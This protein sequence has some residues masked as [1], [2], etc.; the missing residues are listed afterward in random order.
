VNKQLVAVRFEGD[1]VPAVGTE[2]LQGEQ[3][4]GRVTSCCWS[5]RAA[6]PQAIAMVKRGANAVGTSLAWS[7]GAGTVA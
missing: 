1:A 6:Q 2:L 4:V 7:G 3:G 5:P